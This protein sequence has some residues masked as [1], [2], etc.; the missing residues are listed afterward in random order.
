M[1]RNGYRAVN[2]ARNVHL[3]RLVVLR[4]TGTVLGWPVLAEGETVSLWG[5]PD[6]GPLPNDSWCLVYFEVRHDWLAAMVERLPG[7]SWIELGLSRGRYVLDV[8]GRRVRHEDVAR[9]LDRSGEAVDGSQFADGVYQSIEV[10][11]AIGIALNVRDPARC[12]QYLGALNRV[13]PLSVRDVQAGARSARASSGRRDR[14]VALRAA[15]VRVHLQLDRLAALNGSDLAMWDERAGW[16]SGRH[17]G[18]AVRAGMRP[19]QIHADTDW[20]GVNVI[21]ALSGLSR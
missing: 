13:V 14:Q 7:Q 1:G 8:V 20:E 11:D 16:L 12:V 10:P 9:A 3:R 4:V 17:A 2:H 6:P 19:E 18:L 5:P 21:A 15:V